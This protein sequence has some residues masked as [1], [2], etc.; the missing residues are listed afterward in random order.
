MPV[1]LKKAGDGLNRLLSIALALVNAKGKMLLIDEF[2]VG[3]H[4]S[5]QEKLWEIVF[6]YAKKWDIQVF[7]T[8]HSEDTIH[9]FTNIAHKIEFEGMAN[10]IRLQRTRNQKDIVSVVNDVHSLEIA[11]EQDIEIR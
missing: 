2:E 9:A 10:Y 3:L 8:T 11:L 6:G 4:H 7:A 5:V 1:P